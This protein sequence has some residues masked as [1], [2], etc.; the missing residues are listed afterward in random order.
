MRALG[1]KAEGLLNIEIVGFGSL[2]VIEAELGDVLAVV[3]R[4]GGQ[5]MAEGLDRCELEIMRAEVDGHRL[6]VNRLARNPKIPQMNAFVDD[7]ETTNRSS[8]CT[9]GH[10]LRLD[11]SPTDWSQVLDRL[12][13]VIVV[14]HASK[15]RGELHEREGRLLACHIHCRRATGCRCRHGRYL[16][17]GVPRLIDRVI[18]RTT[19]RVIDRVTIA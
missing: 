6:V 12:E 19:D 16:C 9:F 7:T 11:S 13:E 14:D 1:E 8:G 2:A 10:V 3:M 15:F 18:D 5:E 17:N 4:D